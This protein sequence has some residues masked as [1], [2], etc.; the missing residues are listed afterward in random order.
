MACFNVHDP[1]GCGCGGC[2][3]TICV[4]ACG[5]GAAVVGATVTIKSG[6]VTVSSGTTGA[7][8]CVAL[9]IP[10]AGTFEVVISGT[11]LV[12]YDGTRALSCGGT[13]TIKVYATGSASVCWTVDGCCG[14][15]VG[16]ATISIGGVSLTTDATGVACWGVTDAGTYPYTISAGSRFAVHS[17]S[18]TLTS[19]QAM[20]NITVTLTPA[21]GYVC[22]VRTDDAGDVTPYPIPTTLTLSDSI[23]GGCTLTWTGASWVGT[24]TVSF[25]GCL[26]PGGTISCPSSSFVMKY[27]LS[28]CIGPQAAGSAPG[29]YLTVGYSACNYDECVGGSPT[30]ILTGCPCAAAIANCTGVPPGGFILYHGG[31]TGPF[32]PSANAIS[33]VTQAVSIPSALPFDA[34]FTYTHNA[35]NP[36]GSTSPLYPSGGVISIVE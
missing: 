35:G 1:G 20:A 7:G 18:V 36:C 24:S 9:A 21:A 8:G 5:G 19:C 3:T 32:T 29:A 27:E 30:T 6:G 10:A 2:S 15:A 17:G 26:S 11:G 14:N 13:A 25:S 31:A 4:A 34:I 16:G 22:G 33:N 28:G 23:Y 12:T